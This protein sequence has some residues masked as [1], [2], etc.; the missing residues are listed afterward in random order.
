MKY[1]I[2]QILGRQYQL[3]EGKTITVERLAGEVGDEITLDQILLLVDEKQKNL[4]QPKI[5]NATATVKIL[6]HTQDK[7]IR[8]ATYKA[9]ARQRKIKGHRSKQTKILIESIKT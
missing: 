9:K 1:V 7:K 5:E 2:A 3:Q 4:G 8:V 6:A